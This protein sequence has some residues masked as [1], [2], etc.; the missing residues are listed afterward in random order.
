MCGFCM[1]NSDFWTRIANLYGSQVSPVVLCLQCSVISTRTTCL[2]GSQPSCVIFACKTTTFGPELQV[3]KDT[4]PHLS[5]CAYKTVCLALELLVSMGPS[6]HVWFLVAKQRLMDRNN[7]SLWV[8]GITC[9]FVH[10]KSVI[11]TRMTSLYGFQASSFFFSP[12][13]TAPL[14]PDLQVCMG[15]RSDLW[16]WAHITAYLAQV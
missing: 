9:R 3:S 8:Q 12:S 2:Y 7:K 5:F 16:F 1:Q 14:R 15:P 11:C 4:R 13:K 6:P 10:A